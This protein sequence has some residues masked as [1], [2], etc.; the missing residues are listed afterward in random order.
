V[1]ELLEAAPGL[2]IIVTT[3]LPLR[4]AG[5]Q[6][7]SVPPLAEA[8]A[9]TLFGAR[10]RA[11]DPDFDPGE[12]AATIAAICDRLD[13]LPLAIEL[14]AARVKLLPPPALLERLGKGLDLLSA[15]GDHVPERQ[16]TLRAAI[17][18][19]YRLLG[20]RDAEL[21]RHLAVFSGG[22]TIDAVEAVCGNAERDVLER[23]ESLLDHNL[24]RRI[25]DEDGE[26]RFAM[27]TTIRDYAREKL[28]AAGEAEAARFRHATWYSTSAAD[29]G[30]KLRASGPEFGRLLAR[31]EREHDN[32]RAALTWAHGRGQS[33]LLLSLCGALWLFWYVHNH[34]R[35]GA[36]WLEVAVAIPTSQ[37][38]AIRARVL[39][40]A[41][42]FAGLRGDLQRAERL[43]AESLAVYQKLGDRQGTAFLLRDSGVA[44]ARRGDFTAAN[45]FYE[46]SAALFR[47]FG[48]RRAL[49]IVISN[50]G[51]LAFRQGDVVSAKAFCGE[52]LALQREIGTT[53]DIIISLQNLAFA[54][55]HEGDIEDAQAGLEESLLL[56]HDLDATSSIGYALEGLGAV[57][58]AQADWERA[59]RLLGRADAIRVST[60]A[61]LEAGEQM[62]HDRTLSAL[63]DACS[64]D[65]LA[66]A[67]SAG[68][69]LTDDE[70]IGLALSGSSSTP[71]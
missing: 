62:I 25:R 21:F 69:S 36:R 61:E 18:W 59:A 57:A 50:L 22:W 42:V 43:T 63:R 19:S 9:M 37:P 49:A 27:L 54:A 11:L 30:A 20:D 58:A 60:E 34:V 45:S 7:Y 53:F 51:D 4:I 28:E 23:L 38:S 31:L 68:A 44:A 5:E 35:E 40:G 41:S 10:A 70:A 48:D 15:R 8:D 56:A 2:K 3:R 66:A 52:S 47:E 6:E 14:A 67:M 55:L 24:V 46:E 17:D 65:E 64:G 16:R 71:A 29:A 39:Q 26:R 12:S 32:L 1:A 33:E 13:G